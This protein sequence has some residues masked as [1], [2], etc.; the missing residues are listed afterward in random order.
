MVAEESD[1]IN[2]FG[3]FREEAQMKPGD[4]RAYKGERAVV[5]AFGIW[6]SK[7]RGGWLNI[8]MTGDNR[9][10]KHTTVT[11]NPQSRTMYNKVLFRDLRQLLI[12]YGKWPLSDRGVETGKDTICTQ[13]QFPAL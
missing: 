9:N 3:Q 8:H 6:A 10:F 4:V 2:S 13:A 7:G 5:A 11:N 1:S 12:A